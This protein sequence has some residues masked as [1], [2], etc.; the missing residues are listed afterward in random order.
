MDLLIDLEKQARKAG[1]RVHALLGNHEVMNMLGDLRYVTPE[2][3]ASYR[4][5]ESE[6]LRENVFVAN[7]DPARREDPAYRSAWMADKPLG[8]VELMLAFSK[9]GKYGRWLRQHDTVAK[10]GGTLFLHGGI[11]PKYATLQADEINARIKTALASDTPGAEP[12]L[13]DQDGPLWYRGLALGPEAEL[14]PHV[15]ALLAFHGV[16]RIVIGH[17]VAP[18]VVLPRFGGKVILN[19]VGLSAVYGGPRSSLE[20]KGDSVS[21]RHRGTLLPVP[22]T[23]DLSTY[24]QAARAL[25]PA[26]STLDAWVE[27][28]AIWPSSAPAVPQR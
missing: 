18:G 2:E 26:G 15:D 21:V 11:G 22:A 6:K 12:L 17:T 13:T 14:G 25:E 7:A 20:I 23:A 3:Y 16:S 5:L 10:I 24:L 1:G 28:G 27:K 19:D 8:W 4:S 9:Q